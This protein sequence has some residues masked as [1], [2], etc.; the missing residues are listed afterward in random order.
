MGRREGGGGR[1]RGWGEGNIKP[2]R[3]CDLKDTCLQAAPGWE[4][5]SGGA[6]LSRRPETRGETAEP[7]VCPLGTTL[8]GSAPPGTGQWEAPVVPWLHIRQGCGPRGL[9]ALPQPRP[10]P[11]AGSL[12]P[13]VARASS[14][15]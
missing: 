14:S 12:S 8:M 3:R 11:V 5:G 4:G 6:A 10:V 7:H 15:L 13:G 1:G 9:R 2:C